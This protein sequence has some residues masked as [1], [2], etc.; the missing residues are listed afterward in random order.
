M[1][2]SEL[3][4]ATPVANVRS[5]GGGGTKRAAAGGVSFPSAQ[6]K[7]EAQPALS[8]IQSGDSVVSPA[9]HSKPANDLIVEDVVQ[10]AEAETQPEP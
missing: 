7:P 8:S 9:Q 5:T 4:E 10:E 3:M 1:V 2:N 6:P